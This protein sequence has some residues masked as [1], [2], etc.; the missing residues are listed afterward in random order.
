MVEVILKKHVKNL[1][2]KHQ[3]LQVKDGYA[4]YL[5]AQGSAFLGTE[6]SKK[7]LAETLRQR[8]SK[9]TKLQAEVA[10]L[11]KKLDTI[12]LVLLE[13][14][15]EAGNLF[16]AITPSKLAEAYKTNHIVINHKKISIINGPIKKLG[17]HQAVISID[18]DIDKTVYF[19]IR[20]K[21]SV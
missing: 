9:D 7:N 2:E 21:E 19:E 18:K 20:N 3:L 4:N 14:V 11:S 6:S 10:K 15:D 1:G 12:Q 8:S 17:K 16:A 5:I 13:K